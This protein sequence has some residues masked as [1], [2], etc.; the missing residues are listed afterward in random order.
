LTLHA[1]LRKPPA[2]ARCYVAN[3]MA[4]WDVE[5]AHVDALG[6]RIARPAT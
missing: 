5:D 2:S 1:L 3:G 4:V 6:E